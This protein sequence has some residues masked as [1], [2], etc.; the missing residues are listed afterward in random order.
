M[1]DGC[2]TQLGLAIVYSAA[3][4]LMALL[5]RVEGTRPI[6]LWM[7][8]FLLLALDAA[9]SAL[10]I[11]GGLPEVLR[12][13]AWLLLAAGALV[14]LVGTMTFIGQRPSRWV[15]VFGASLGAAVGGGLVLGV[16]LD[17]LRVVA[18]EG[19]AVLLAWFGLVAFRAGLE[20]GAGRWV[21]SSAFL[22]AAVY[23]ALWP[24]LERL[25]LAERFEFFL[26]TSVLLW[27]AMGVL[28]MHYEG[29]RE[30]ALRLGAQELELRERL[31]RAERVEALGR[32][33]AGV[34][35]DF[36]NVLTVMVNG[37]EVVLR[38]LR[39]R[40]EAAA[41]LRVVVDA[42]QGAAGFTR[43][44]LALG[45]Q[46]LP[47]RSPTSLHDALDVA[48]R[49]VR[50]SLPS[51]VAVVVA[52]DGHDPCVLAAE[53]QLEQVIVNLVLNAIDAMSGGGNIE[54]R[55]VSPPEATERV[56]LLV[57]DDGVGMDEATQS[58]IFD[59]YVTT[60]TWGRGSGLGLSTVHA[61]VTQLDGH[62]SVSSRSGVG[63][64]FTV[65][66]PTCA[67]GQSL[68]EA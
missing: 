63:T 21:G 2:I 17:L 20:G 46:K 61:I 45:R 48:L 15:Y 11:A 10:V 56:R 4:G 60:K 50:P 1:S 8:A 9:L 24:A 68:T 22:G 65:E 40:P 28:L 32:L 53:G 55:T 42:A 67:A 51:S 35:H 19:I 52:R 38:Q 27:G 3:A 7:V 39:D 18:F 66:L 64:T 26:D 37:S 57:R 41:K 16:S 58:R 44:L 59:P 5:H 13:A 33:A 6:A 54:I 23:A 49:I 36:N 29:A 47:A 31:A 30:R 12:G 25:G 14:G 62:I 43:Q 34:A